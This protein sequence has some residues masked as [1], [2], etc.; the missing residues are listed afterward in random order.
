MRANAEFHVLQAMGSAFRQLIER[1]LEAPP[2]HRQL[3]HGLGHRLA[4][5]G[6]GLT[7]TPA[8]VLRAGKIVSLRLHLAFG[9]DGGILQGFQF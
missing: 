8:Q 9:Q 4:E 5:G 2:R 6:S 7:A 1:H 3:L